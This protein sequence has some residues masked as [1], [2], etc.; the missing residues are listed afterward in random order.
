LYVVSTL[1]LIAVFIKWRERNL[2]K[3]KIVLETKVDLRTKELD[4]RNKLVEEQKKIVEE[5]Q[6]EITQSINYAK[7]IQSS[8][9][10]SE[11]YISKYLKDYFILFN[12]RDIV[13][14]DFYWVMENNN[15]LYVCTADCTGHGIPGAFM[16]LIGM[17]VLNEI[18][19]SKTHLNHTDEFLNELRRIIILALN[20]E[21]SAEEGK[22]GMD[23]VLC[24]YDFKKMELE[25]S[26]ANNS[27]YIVRNG[28]LL[29][30]KPDKI[31]VGK[32]LEEEKPFTRHLISLQK[33]DCIYTFTDGY[34]DQ[35]GGPK[36][37]K[38][39]YKQFEEILLANAH[40]P[41][42]EQ[43]EILK[44]CFEEWKGQLEQVDDVCIIGIKV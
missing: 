12:P 20:P 14:G 40:L 27:F 11:K 30:Y 43:K 19:H 6:N 21:G 17:G 38:F 26:A 32:Y 3:E 9:L 18:S 5:K 31:P 13:S 41:M 33:G 44:K 35:F 29:E 39:K 4:D 24:R 34:A 23:M 16:S 36:G 37:K 7:R 42:Q 10:S 28:E 8:F 25:Y 1:S 22:D 2:K 15:S